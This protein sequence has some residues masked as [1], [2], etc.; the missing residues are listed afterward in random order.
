MSGLGQQKVSGSQALLCVIA[1][2][3]SPLGTTLH[4][5]TLVWVY[6][7]LLVPPLPDA[8]VPCGCGG[9]EPP[10]DPSSGNSAPGALFGTDSHGV[11][12]LMGWGGA[13]AGPLE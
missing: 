3:T 7:L 11:R 1:H 9:L 6:P 8:L 12:G 2:P 13:T 10:G 5:G 4:M